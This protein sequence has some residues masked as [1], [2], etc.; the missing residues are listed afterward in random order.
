MDVFGLGAFDQDSA[1]P[2]YIDV[3]LLFHL[4]W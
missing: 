1:L 4:K 2:Q 3:D